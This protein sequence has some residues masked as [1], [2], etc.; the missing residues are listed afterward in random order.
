MLGVTGNI[1]ASCDP[2][3]VNG[4]ISGSVAWGQNYLSSNRTTGDLVSIPADNLKVSAFTLAVMFS[5]TST[6]N[7]VMVEVNGNTGISMQSGGTPNTSVYFQPGNVQTGVAVN[8]GAPHVIV[9][10]QKRIVLDGRQLSVVLSAPNFGTAASMYWFSRNG[11]AGTGVAQ[12]IYAV[13]WWARE[14]SLA[15]SVLMC[16]DPFAPLRRR[17]VPVFDATSAL[18]RKLLLGSD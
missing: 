7:G 15:E 11:G 3:R 16:A 12:R 10:S 18:R 2:M 1:V 4:T 6:I 8:D 14:L 9:A 13:M 17:D 5:L